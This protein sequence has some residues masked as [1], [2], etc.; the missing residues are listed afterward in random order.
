MDF[1]LAQDFP[2]EGKQGDVPGAFDR[3]GKLTLVLGA[4][5]GLAAWTDLTVI[6]DKPAENFDQFIID[7]GRFISAELAFPRA[8]EETSLPA[9]LVVG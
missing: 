9:L 8:N 1:A 7:G 3:R 2:V 4:S 6:G 5:S